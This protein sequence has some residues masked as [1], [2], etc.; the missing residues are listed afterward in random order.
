M[1]TTYLDTTQESGRNFYLNEMSGHIVMLNLLRFC[2]VADYSASPE[3]A[4]TN[5]SPGR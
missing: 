4:P 1:S 2:E 3:L 5:P